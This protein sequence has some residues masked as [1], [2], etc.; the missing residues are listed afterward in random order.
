LIDMISRMGGADAVAAMAARVGISPQQAHDAMVAMVPVLASGMTQQAQAGNAAA[1]DQMSGTAAALTGSAASDEAV[2]YGTGILGQLLGGEQGSAAM[3]Q[4]R[5]A[6][7]GIDAGALAALMPM[8]AT[9]ATSALGNAT[10]TVATPAANGG[11]GGMLGGLFGGG[12]TG[13]AAAAL[14]SMIDT[15]KDGSPLDEIMGMASSFLKR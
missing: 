8:V 10:G 7:T 4:G 1:I 6:K 3:A 9:L 11:L 15:N 12:H 2:A 14:M 5:A 13:G